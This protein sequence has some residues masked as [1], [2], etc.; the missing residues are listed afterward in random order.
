MSKKLPSNSNENGIVGKPAEP[1]LE[2]GGRPAAADCVAGTPVAGVVD[3][4][5]EDDDVDVLE[6]E[7]E[8]DDD[9]ASVD[10]PEDDDE[11]PAD[12]RA[13]ACC[14][15]G[16]AGAGV[17]DAASLI[18]RKSMCDPVETWLIW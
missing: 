6:D 4:V 14:A 2:P 9:D 13:A 12:D 11:P 7:E 18:E 10:V 17:P 3:V 1:T 5:L 15:A 16:A 8:L